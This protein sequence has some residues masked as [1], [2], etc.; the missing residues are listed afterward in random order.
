MRRRGKEPATRARRRSWRARLF[1][2]VLSGLFWVIV[3]GTAWLG[4]LFYTLQGNQGLFK[5]PEREPG[6]MLIARDGRVLAERGA[7]FGDEARI[8]ELPRHLPLAVVAIEDR[9]FYHHWGVD[10]IGLARAM[11]TNLR[12]GRIV[13]GGSTLTQQLAKNLFLKHERTYKRKI[14]ELLLAWWLEWRFTKNEILQ[15][16]LNR[17]YF[18]AGAWGVERAARRFFGKSARDVTIGEAAVLAGVLKAPSRY[19]PVRHRERALAR[20][21]VVLKAMVEAGYITRAQAAT[22]LRHVG[23]RATAARGEL[24]ATNYVV[25]WV[26]EQLPDLIGEFRESLVVETTID[27]DLQRRAER[28]LRRA[29]KAHGRRLRVGQGALLSM[30]PDGAVRALIGG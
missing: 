25:D 1:M 8:D 29:L 22:A 4:Y 10:V 5:I 13:Q 11:L 27:R 28:L 6:L 20:A 19:N 3:L 30:A 2:G 14:Q 12:A 17:V 18:G 9:R 26:L 24:P 21:R 16:Y 7:F 15:L 23:R